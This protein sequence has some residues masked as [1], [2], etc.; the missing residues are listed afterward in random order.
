MYT[1]SKFGT[2]T[3]VIGLQLATVLYLPIRATRIRAV[4]TEISLELAP[5]DPYDILSG[6]Y[7]DLNYVGSQPDSFALR[8]FSPKVGDTVFAVFRKGPSKVWQPVGIYHSWPDR[9]ATNELVMKGVF[10]KENWRTQI[11]YGVERLYIPETMRQE[12]GERITASLQPEARTGKA[13]SPDLVRADMKVDEHGNPSL[14]R[15]HIGDKVYE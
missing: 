8:T 10:G 5:V 13:P 1:L 11:I 6:Y 15:L 3:I 14:L 7:V 9:L 2:F 12:V 4:G